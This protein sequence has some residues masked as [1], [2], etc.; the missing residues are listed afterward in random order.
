MRSEEQEVS[1]SEASCW[2]GSGCAERYDREVNR[3]FYRAALARLL[4]RAPELHGRG[5]DLGCGTGF[6]T[7]VLVAERPGVA[8]Q[9]VDCSAAMLQIARGKPGLGQ[10]DLREA[11]AEALPF[12]D[13]S[14]DVVVANFSW[15]WF[16][17]GAGQ[18]VRRVLRR[19]GWLLASMPVRRLSLARG[20]RALARALL[21]G[22]QRFA[23]RAS[24][25]FRFAELPK[26]LPAPVWVA[27]H[28][29][30]VEGEEFAD[31]RQMLDVL[32]SRGAL[33]AIFGA[34]PP[35][36]IEALGPVDYEWPFA[37]LHVQ[38]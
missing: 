36:A 35:V 4:E 32:G 3:K 28:E 7:E 5:L 1:S 29:L 13:A 15:H 37:V 34:Q 33:A 24:Q 38:V 17:D 27:R 9:G 12:A 18:E 19:N 10:V 14:F 25:G 22:R 21:A 2:S 16:G 6:S 31:G 11:H 23:P 26:L 20:N 8:W 30:L